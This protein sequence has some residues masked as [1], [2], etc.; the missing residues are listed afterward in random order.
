MYEKEIARCTSLQKYINIFKVINED[1]VKEKH[2]VDSSKAILFSL[3]SKIEVEDNTV[4][5]LR[6][7]KA[8]FFW[9]MRSFKFIFLTKAIL[10]QYKSSF[11]NNLA[12]RGA[13]TPLEFTRKTKGEQDRKYFRMVCIFI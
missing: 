1:F 4:D 9:R 8:A 10:K 5:S 12:V 11:S 6:P 2:T 3:V 13:Y 7:Y